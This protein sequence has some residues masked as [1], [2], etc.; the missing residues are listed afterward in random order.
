[1]LQRKMGLRPLDLKIQRGFLLL[2][3][4]PKMTGEQKSVLL[5]RF[6]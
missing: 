1:M 5:S 4:S 2:R 6:K 3:L